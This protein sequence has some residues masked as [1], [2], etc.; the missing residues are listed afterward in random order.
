MESTVPVLDKT[1]T[2]SLQPAARIEYTTTRSLE[3]SREVLRRHRLIAG[4]EPGPYLDAYKVLRTKVLQI[5]REHGWN[6]LAV[7][8]PNPQAGKTVAAINLALSLA[9]DVSQTVLLVDAN[10]RRPAV[11][12]AF[13][14]TPRY[15]LA[16]YL[17][18]DVP[19]ERLL[20]NPKGIGRFVILPGSR[21]LPDSA[22][23]LASPKMARLVDELKH[24]YPSRIVVFD[25]PHLTTADAL[26]F[27]PHVD[28]AL[29]VIE[30]GR[31]TQTQLTD[32]LTQLSTTPI[33]GTLLNKAEPLP[34]P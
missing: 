5:L 18:D 21:P 4:Y 27:A 14:F 2:A 7:T 1:R 8:S 6:A 31:T 17:L 22:E 30:A 10:L 16:D 26:A 28:A 20:I 23:L 29:L 32:A 3:V 11:H 13:G 33:L 9:L 19:I 24:R 12:T 15:G 25:L 34:E